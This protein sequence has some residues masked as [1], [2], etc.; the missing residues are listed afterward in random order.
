MPLTR[1]GAGLI[2]AVVA[3]GLTA[4]LVVSALAGLAGLQRTVGRFSGR[5]MSDQALRGTAQ[6]LRSELRD[7]APAAG[8]LRA[9]GPG[10]ITYRA[11][12]GAGQACGLAPGRLLV[13]AGS[14]APLRQPAAGRDSL[15]LLAQPV[16]TEVVVAASGSAVSGI[17][18]DGV[19]SVSLPYAVS[20]PDPLTAALFP[21]PVLLAEV[22]E[23]RAYQ[24]GGEWWVGVRSVSAGETIQ[25]AHGPIAPG[26]LRINAFDAAGAPTLVP[27]L[28]SH[29]L[30]TVLSAGGDSLEVR[31]DFTRGAWK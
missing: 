30:F 25:P 22:M 12:R 11:V 2:E 16:D 10:S 26:G 27:A 6:L 14:W 13:L 31:L 5:V 1:R 15:V 23:I 19:V 17:C 18:P 21:A 9:I 20:T 28:V 7:L 3:A 8:E 24:S 4:L 29:L